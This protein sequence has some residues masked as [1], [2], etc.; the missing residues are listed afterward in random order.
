MSNWI[1]NGESGAS[2][3]AKLNSLM[4]PISSGKELTPVEFFDIALPA[5]YDS[6][7]LY[8]N[9]IQLSNLQVTGSRDFIGFTFSDDGGVTF[10]NGATD[11]G[12]AMIGTI[13]T[14]GAFESLWDGGFFDKMAYIAPFQTVRG[15]APDPPNP[16]CGMINIF[17]G[18]GINS[19]ILNVNSISTLKGYFG[20]AG[21]AAAFGS[22]MNYLNGIATRQNAMRIQPSGNED[23]NPPTSGETISIASWMLFGMPTPT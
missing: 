21:G 2:V 23:A 4:I 12:Y 3:R 17:P 22:G 13:A 19:A 20:N 11:Y 5:G 10:H 16:T 14:T 8:V 6:F 9:G 18:D 1:A 15:D 7:L